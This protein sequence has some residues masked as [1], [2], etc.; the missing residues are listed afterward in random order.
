MGSSARTRVAKARAHQ[1]GYH[2]LNHLNT[3]PRVTYLARIRNPNPALE[4]DGA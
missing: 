2:V 1:R 4:D 3:R